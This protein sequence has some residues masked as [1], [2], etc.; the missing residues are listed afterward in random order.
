MG[1]STGSSRA[2]VEVRDMRDDD[3][4]EVAR[5]MLRHYGERA[6]ELMQDRSRN[7]R[8]HD[9]LASADYWDGVAQEVRRIRG[10]RVLPYDGSKAPREVSG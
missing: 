1:S 5:T 7:C 3:V 8:R 9:E 2:E 4:A 10:L 6:H